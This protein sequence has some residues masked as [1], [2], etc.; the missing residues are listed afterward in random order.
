[1]ANFSAAFGYDF[2]ILPLASSSVDVAFT[3]VTS[4]TGTAP[5]GF[6]DISSPASGAVSYSAGVFTVGGTTYAMDG[7]DDP[8]RLAGLTTA[9]LET[10]TGAEDIYTYDNATKGFN[11]AVATTK[12]F[13][14]SLSGIAD[15]TDTGYQI[16]RLAEANT[17]ADSLKV[18][19][20]RVG[21]TG[22]TEAVYGYGTLMGY[23]ESNEVT[24]IVSWECT[25]GGYGAYKI[26]LA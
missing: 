13:S 24:S 4:A 15:F 17:V 25:I 12:S 10:D 26:D 6:I 23:T 1:M 19:L 3:N 16:L 7:T 9:S 22:T 5:G 2:Y 18:K 8:V 20:V 11:Q 21:P 14:I